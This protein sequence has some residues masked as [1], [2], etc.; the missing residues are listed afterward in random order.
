MHAPFASKT[1]DNQWNYLQIT[2]SVP[3][4]QAMESQNREQQACMF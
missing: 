3:K 4:S 2:N 1:V